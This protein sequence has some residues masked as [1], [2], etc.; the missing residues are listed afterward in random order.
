[1]NIKVT[2]NGEPFNE[3]KFKNAPEKQIIG[4]T[5]LRI[6]NTI[7]SVLSPEEQNQICV[8]IEEKNSKLSVNLSGQDDIIRRVE[9]A[10]GD[11][12]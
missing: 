3:E 9:L 4:K 8:N 11:K 7:K 1:M 6:K 5:I 12:E 10:L 2:F